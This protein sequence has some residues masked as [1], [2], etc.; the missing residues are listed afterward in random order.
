MFIIIYNDYKLKI[1]KIIVALVHYLFKLSTI[2][3]IYVFDRYFNNV[4]LLLLST[5]YYNI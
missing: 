3:K 5:M 4:T 1:K 2:L